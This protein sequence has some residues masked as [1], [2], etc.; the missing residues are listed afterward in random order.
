MSESRTSKKFTKKSAE[1]FGGKLLGWYDREGRDLPWRYKGGATPDPYRVWLSEIMLQQTTVAAVGNYFRKFTE[2]WPDIHTLAAAEQADVMDA[3]AGLGYYTRARNLHKCAQIVAR[4]H[5]G[6]FPQDQVQLQKLPGIGLYTSAAIAAIAFNRP[7][8][9]VDGNVE[10]VMARVFAVETPMPGSKKELYGLA[11]GLFENIK[12]RP[13]DLA[14]ALMDLGATVCTPRSPRC[15]GCP[16]ADFCTA[17]KSGAAEDF[18]FFE[19][20]KRKPEKTGYVFI[21]TN[22]KGQVLLCRRPESGLLA[23][24]V[25]LPTSEWVEISEKGRIPEFPVFLKRIKKGNKGRGLAVRHGFTHFNLEL[26]LRFYEMEGDVPEGGYF[27]VDQKMLKD[28][29]FPTL[30]G[31]VVKLL[32]PRIAD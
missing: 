21:V 14:Q 20:K 11:A 10:R 30:F 2:I 12:E 5:G 23:R 1:R 27:W 31:K 25:G 17:Q 13:G 32:P 3:W 28:M 26:K 19:A 9:V 16:V 18:P 4:E 7:A 24:M 22:K 29:K 8:A 6:I 15:G